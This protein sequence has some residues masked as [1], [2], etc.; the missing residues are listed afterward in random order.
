MVLL[1]RKHS[2]RAPR[3][4]ASA[5]HHVVHPAAVPAGARVAAGVAVEVAEAVGADGDDKNN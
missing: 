3:V 4:P 5:R 1:T 2:F